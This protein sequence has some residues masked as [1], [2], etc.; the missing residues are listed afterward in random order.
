MKSTKRNAPRRGWTLRGIASEVLNVVNQLS[1]SVLCLSM[2]AVLFGAMSASAATKNTKYVIS[3]APTSFTFAFTIDGAAPS[4]QTVIFISTPATPLPFTMSAN[5][6]WITMSATS[7]VTKST[8]QLGVNP[9]GLAAGTYS[10]KVVVTPTGAG[11]PSMT[12]PVSL[13]VSPAPVVAPYVISAAPTAFSFTDTVNGAAPA[14]QT[15][16]FISTP[17]TPLPFTMAANQSWITMSA[18]SGVTK[19]TLQL[20]VNP[21][22]MAAG[23]YSGQ[24]VVTP[25]GANNPP[26]TIPVSLTLTAAQVAPSISTQPVSQTVTTGQT[27]SFS[28]TASGTAP[29][30]YQWNKNAAAIA[31]ATSSSYTTPATASTDSA[32]IFTVTVSNAVSTITSSSATL[33]VNTNYVISAAPT[34]F[35]FAATANGTTPALQ[36]VI[37]ISTPATPSPFNMSANQSWITMSATSGVTKSTLQLGVNLT[38]LAAGSYTGQIIVTPTG[39]GDPPITIPV[40]L[41]VAAAQLAPTISG[42]P[43]SQTVT[44]GQTATFS[45]SASGAA[46]MSYQWNKNAVAIA[47]ATGSSYTTAATLSTDNGSVFTVAVSNSVNSVTSNSATLTVN[48][49]YVIS[50]APTA[51]TF[52]ATVNGTTPALQTVIFISTPATPL[53]FTMSTTQSWI[54]MSASSGVTKSTLQFGVNTTGL[55][56]GSYSGQVLV[57]PTGAGDPPMTIPVSLTVTAATPGTLTSSLSTLAFSSVNV[58]TSI[59]MQAIL[60]NSGNSTVDITNVSIS[61]AGFTVSGVPSGTILAAGQTATLSVAFD[62]S[63]AGNATGSVT[64]T[65]NASNSSDSITLSGTGVQAVS[66]SVSLTWVAGTGTVSGYN[67]YQSTVSGGTFTKLNSSLNSSEAYTD[68]TVQAGQTYYY[69]VTSVNAAGT[70]SV[71]SN[72]VSVLIP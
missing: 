14:L 50:A 34:A 54:T 47:G 6:S 38:G 20:G 21:A 49:N 7:G 55:A 32:S 65:S 30:T 10:G 17:A 64:I 36:T 44:M 41:T 11:D 31:G 45:V 42:Q 33:T 19:S 39:A 9:A 57:T 43:V 60:T 70:E 3:A 68:T 51:F 12:I 5:Q 63:T 13:T 26:M 29:L 56:A 72:Q 40:S 18:N 35:S 16:I 67:T 4:L 46:P 62:P 48:T 24:V 2:T 52:A 22:G 27:A 37:F 58:S 23:T 66:H 15:V 25:T 8:L 28:V 1:L 61:G 53:P 59:S 71:Y 69:V